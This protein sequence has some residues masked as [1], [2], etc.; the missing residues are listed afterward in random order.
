MKKTCWLC[1]LMCLGCRCSCAQG[2]VLAQRR[3]RYL[4]LLPSTRSGL[5]CITSAHPDVQINYQSIGSG[6]GIRQLQAGTVDFGASDGPMTDEQLAQSKIQDPAFPHGAGRRCAH[7]QHPGCNRRSEFHAEGAG[8]NL[9]RQDHE[10]ERS[11]NR[12]SQSGREAARAP[13]SS[14]CTAPTAAAP[15]TSGPT[16]SPRSARTGRT[17]SAR[18]TPP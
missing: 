17:K 14:S 4:S 13:T 12:E 2:G 15:P 10:V 8:R 5:T 16:I 18:P 9:P 6:G 11:G 3:W 1:W 7:L